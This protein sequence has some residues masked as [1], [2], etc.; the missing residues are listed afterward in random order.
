MIKR[1][2]TGDSQMNKLLLI[3]VRCMYY[4]KI[5]RNCNDFSPALTLV[6]KIVYPDNICDSKIVY[7]FFSFT[8]DKEDILRSADLPLLD[9]PELYMSAEEGAIHEQVIENVSISSV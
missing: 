8:D 5:F 7:Y 1:C 9:C 2:V 3:Y 4:S 6:C